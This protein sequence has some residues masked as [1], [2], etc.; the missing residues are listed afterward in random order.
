MR[1]VVGKIG[2]STNFP[3]TIINRQ[4]SILNFQLESREGDSNPL[5]TGYDNQRINALGSRRRY[6]LSLHGP[7]ATS[8]CIITFKAAQLEVR[9]IAVG[10]RDFPA[11]IARDQVARNRLCAQAT[12]RVG[13]WQELM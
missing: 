7:A 5:E 4:Q 8:D 6:L 12:G 10:R 3:R 2:K 1:I 9:G 13:L 11:G